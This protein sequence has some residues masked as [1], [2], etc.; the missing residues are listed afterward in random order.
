MN[1]EI[2]Y[3]YC[4]TNKINSK[5]YIGQTNDIERRK[6]QHIQDSKHNHNEARY[7]QIIHQAMRKYGFE[8]FDFEILD[9][10]FNRQEANEKENYWIK[11]FNTMAPNGYNNSEGKLVGVRKYE[12]KLTDEQLANLIEDLK[13]KIT[14]KE[15]AKKYNISYS[16]V[17]DINN[18]SRL[19][20]KDLTYPIQNNKIPDSFYLEVI[21]LLLNSEMTIGE[22]A[23]K[24]NKTRDNISNINN[25]KLK[26]VQKLYNGTFPLRN[27]SKY[28]N[29]L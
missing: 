19:K 2:V 14:M 21:D 23:K 25:G 22:I 10:C 24:Y 1:N 27:N 15:I 7:N 13:N 5:K 4:Y 16:Y 6:K 11:Y 26:I 18:G 9:T 12:S 8:N 3:I 28:R 20:Q 17:S 29:K